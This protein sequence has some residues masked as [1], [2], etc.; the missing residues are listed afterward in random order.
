MCR[1]EKKEARESEEGMIEKRRQRK[2]GRNKKKGRGSYGKGASKKRESMICPIYVISQIPLGPK[3][4]ALGGYFYL[5]LD[6]M[7]S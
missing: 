1:D 5:T 7:V 4:A 6:F 3:K 2:K